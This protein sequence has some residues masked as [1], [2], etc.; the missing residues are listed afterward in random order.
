MPAIKDP[1]VAKPRKGY[2]VVPKKVTRG[3]DLVVIPKEE[4]DRLVRLDKWNRDLDRDLK[5]SIAEMDRG[6]LAGP[7]D[8]VDELR[9]SLEE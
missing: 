8:S 2:I 3:K 1:Q 5:A 6:E 7:F 4:Y 9:K